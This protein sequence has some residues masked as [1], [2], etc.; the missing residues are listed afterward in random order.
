M[1]VSRF[2]E[3][4]STSKK[5]FIHGDGSQSRDVTYVGDVV[6]AFNLSVDDK[7]NGRT[8]D[9]A[10]GKTYSIL[11]IVNEISNLIGIKADIEFIDRPNGDQEKTLG[12]L[13]GAKEFLNY[14]PAVSLSQ[15]LKNQI[16]FYLHKKHND[17]QI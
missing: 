12:S 7:T 10:S 14:H 13:K 3:Q 1:A 9:I 11:T 16:D 4:L 6:R 8:F 17:G 2:I 5:V 15:G